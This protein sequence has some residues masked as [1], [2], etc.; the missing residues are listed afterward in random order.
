MKHIEYKIDGENRI[1][2]GN[3]EWDS[4]ALENYG[5]EIVSEKI[6]GKNLFDYIQDITIKQIYLDIIEK[7]RQGREINI[8]YRCDAPTL[9]RLLKMYVKLENNGIVKFV[10]EPIQITPQQYI[11]LLDPKLPKEDKPI[12]MCSWCKRIKIETE[13]EDLENAINKYQLLVQDK[14][15]FLTHTI[16]EKCFENIKKAI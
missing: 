5:E 8:D 4:F 1:I 2:Y 16:C 7:V 6:L 12:P 14:L 3:E 11:Y 10:S 13:W 9:K 15:P